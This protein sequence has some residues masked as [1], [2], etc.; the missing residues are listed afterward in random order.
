MR[1]CLA[2]IVTD[3]TF[4]HRDVEKLRGFM[5]NRFLE[6][7]IFHNHKG[8]YEF[9]YRFPKVQ[10]KFIDNHLCIY[11]MEDSIEIMQE[12]VK[13]L[14]Y[15]Q[16]GQEQIKINQLLFEEYKDEFKIDTDLHEYEFQTTWLALNQENYPKYKKGEIDLNKQIQN[17]LLSNFK[18]LGIKV[19][20]RI[21][22]KGKFIEEN[23]NVK[24]IQMLGFKGTFVTNVSIPK[25]MSIGKRQSIGFGITKKTSK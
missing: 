8:K 23:V 9:Q 7:D 17:N 4:Y 5:G 15:I 2:K 1:F 18:G 21:M 16:I 3:T 12:S 25:Y 24:D 11:A 20:E 19:E 13:K 10:Y 6:Q 22:A 14:D